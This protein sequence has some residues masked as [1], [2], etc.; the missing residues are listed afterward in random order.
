MIRTLLIL[1][2]LL[3][4]F[5]A[6]AKSGQSNQCGIGPAVPQAAEWT[7]DRIEEFLTPKIA[8]IMLEKRIF[9]GV[10]TVIKDGVP[11]YTH[12]FGKSD[13]K[14]GIAVD[15]D[16]SLFQIGSI[17][18]VMTAIAALKQVESGKLSLTADI[19]RRPGMAKY[20]GK[21]GPITLANLLTHTAGFEEAGPNFY[22][23]IPFTERPPVGP[24]LASTRPAAVYQPGKVRA[25]SNFGVSLVAHMVEQSSGQTFD[26]YLD[27]Q[28]FAPLGMTSTTAKYPL[29]NGFSARMVV[30]YDGAAMAPAEYNRAKGS[31][32]ILTTAPDMAKFMAAFLEPNTVIS[33]T[34]ASDM[35]TPHFRE[36]PCANALGWI[37]WLE[38][39]RGTQL[40]THGG[41]VP[42]G[43]ANMML[44]P[45]HGIG[46]FFAFNASDYSAIDA[47]ENVIVD[48]WFPG[49]KI[50]STSHP[51]PAAGEYHGTRIGVE[52]FGRFA[53]LLGD[54]VANLQH[55]PNN[56]LLYK[57]DIWH[58]RAAGV[59]ESEQ[60]GKTL[61]T[62]ARDG[63]S[64]FVERGTQS[65]VKA[66]FFERSDIQFSLLGLCLI[67]L[68]AA[69]LIWVFPRSK[70][71]VSRWVRLLPIASLVI[72][73]GV[74]AAIAS[75]GT[76]QSAWLFGVPFQVQTAVLIAYLLWPLGIASVV[77]AIMSWRTEQRAFNR[78]THLTAAFAAIGLALWFNHW[79][80]IGSTF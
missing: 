32:E 3:T 29:P 39:R 72:A 14:R 22:A 6:Q 10:A 15:P 28:I 33:R 51:L 19:A 73:L 7:P 48:Q 43:V 80:L 63:N 5:Q 40:V 24:F 45:Q 58:Q 67:T 8:Q 21:S 78:F 38:N 71:S 69:T 41:E 52:N 54:A 61:A 30:G 59:F 11:I 62:F 25:Y 36:A 27:E 70:S 76:E 13:A 65:Y 20:R 44:F 60:G 74:L 46:V 42:G 55:G 4:A 1:A 12:G 77:L 56:T 64:G 79:N 66:S 75:V 50:Q 26:N 35:S 16:R 23:S 57:G 34:V 17:T 9:G 18:K 53:L 47:V 2:A 37:V 31:G 49:G 68:V